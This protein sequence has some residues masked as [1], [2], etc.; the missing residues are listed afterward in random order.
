[1][2]LENWGRWSEIDTSKLRLSISSEN[3][4]IDRTTWFHGDMFGFE[5]WD[6]IFA[7]EEE[8]CIKRDTVEF[9]FKKET[10]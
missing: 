1:M 6:I 8:L 3:S 10:P 5:V 9:L 2:T 4:Y 7:T